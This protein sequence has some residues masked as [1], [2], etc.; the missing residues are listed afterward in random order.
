MEDERVTDQGRGAWRREANTVVLHDVPMPDR[1]NEPFT[2]VSESAFVT[3]PL[4]F[5]SHSHEAHELVWVRGGTMTMRLDDV[6]VT[7]PDGYGLWIP[8]GMA[9][10]GRMTASTVLSDALIAPERSLVSF[11]S[12]TMIEITPLLASL[13]NHLENPELSDAARARAES[14]V[15]DALAPAARQMA[16]QVPRI[17]RLEPI[18]AGLLDDPNDPRSLGEWASLV[19]VS[20]RT[21]ARLFRAHTGL[22]FSQWRQTLRVHHALALRS[23][24]HAVYEV[25]D[26]M[27]FAQPSTF[28][29]SFK[30]VMGVTPGALQ[31]S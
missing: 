27:G 24:G 29:A 1:L 14:V 23:E 4:E 12:A 28:I 9:H 6:I 22:S 10:S 15:F 26:L 7:V 31:G 18:V 21:V 25:S 13:L 2:I 16:L 19:G 3:V 11:E 17:E 8:S 20:E 5:E 30:R